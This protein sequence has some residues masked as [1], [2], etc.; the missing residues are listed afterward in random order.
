[1]FQDLD[2]KRSFSKR[3]YTGIHFLPRRHLEHLAPQFSC[4]L[5][6]AAHTRNGVL[7][8]FRQFCPQTARFRVFTSLSHEDL[9]PPAGTRVLFRFSIISSSLSLQPSPSARFLELWICEKWLSAGD[10]SGA[11]GS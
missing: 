4:V 10:A 8:S 6:P 3:S 5:T 1:M 9:S 11:V 7:S 2:N